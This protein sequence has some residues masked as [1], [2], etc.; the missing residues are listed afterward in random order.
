MTLLEGNWWGPPYGSGICEAALQLLRV[1]TFDLRTILSLRNTTPASLIF[2]GFAAE[3]APDVLDS[4]VSSFAMSCRRSRHA[5]VR[6][7]HPSR[8]ETRT[9]ESSTRASTLVANLVAK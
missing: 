1:S 9:K 5:E 3:T 6:R 2:G 7:S 8:L 4:P